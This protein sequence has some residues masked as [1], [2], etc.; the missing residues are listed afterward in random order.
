MLDANPEAIIQFPLIPMAQFNK[1]L[2]A[3]PIEFGGG[4]RYRIVWAPSRKVLRFVLGLPETLHAYGPG[5]VERMDHKASPEYKPGE[6]WVLEQ[7]CN[8]YRDCTEEKWNTIPCIQVPGLTG[9]FTKLQ[10]MGPFPRRGHYWHCENTWLY[11]E[12]TQSQVERQILLVEDGMLRHTKWD[13]YVAIRELQKR[14]VKEQDRIDEDKVRDRF[15]I[16]GGEAYA[17]GHGRGRGTKTINTT[18]TDKDLRRIG[19][20]T[21]HGTPSATPRR[22]KLLYDLS[23]YVK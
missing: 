4:N 23:P 16:G 14:G 2:G 11:G 17:S 5:G 19:I 12:P 1:T 9:L 15:L 3:V 6:C 21:K 13:N 20:S 8:P 18:R 10:V 7:W 22:K